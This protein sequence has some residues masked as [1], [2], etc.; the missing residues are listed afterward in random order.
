MSMR[1]K[2]QFSWGH[3][4]YDALTRISEVEFAGHPYMSP[5]KLSSIAHM[6]TSICSSSIIWII[7]GVK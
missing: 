1:Y 6:L 4:A 5:R 3:F 2:A 7:W